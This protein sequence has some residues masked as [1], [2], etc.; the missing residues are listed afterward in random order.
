MR[1]L[2]IFRFEISHWSRRFSTWIY[3]GLLVVF[4]LYWT[5]ILSDPAGSTDVN[6]PVQI[7]LVLLIIGFVGVAITA[8]LFTDAAIR[9]HRLKIQPLLLTTPLR[10]WEYLGGR[11]L[12][13]LTINAL[14]LA[15]VPV[16][17]AVGT[18]MPFVDP[19]T[20][21]PFRPRAYIDPYLFLLL[22]GLVF[23]AAVLFGTSLL[24]RRAIS[25]YLTG[26][27]LFVGYVL[28]VAWTSTLQHPQLGTLLDPS[29]LLAVSETAEAWTF[30]ERNA[31]LVDASGLLLWNR[32][33]WMAIGLAVLGVT[34]SRYRRTHVERGGTS[35]SESGTGIAEDRPTSPL[36][37]SFTSLGVPVTAGSFG[38]QARLAQVLAITRWATRRILASREFIAVAV[39]MVVF[40]LLFGGERLEDPRYGV[41]LWPFTSEVIGLLKSFFI[42]TIVT[43]LIA[44]Y[45]GELVWEERDEGVDELTDVA[46]VPVWVSLVGRFVALGG[47]LIALHAVLLLAGILFQ[48]LS[49]YHDF[50]LGFFMKA[51][52]GFQLVD[53]LLIAAVAFFV[54]V[55][56]NQKYAGHGLVL[57]FYLCTVF[58]GRFGIE[59]GLLV[60]GSDPGWIASDFNGF[61]PFI[62]G[63]VWFKAYWAAWAL[64]LVL[65]AHLFWIRG[66]EQSLKQRLRRARGRITRPVAAGITG[67]GLLTLTLGGFVFYNTNVLN[68]YQSSFEAAQAR[69]EYERRYK[70][71]EN[72]AQPWVTNTRLRIEIYPDRGKA[73]AEGS[74][75]LV[76]ETADSIDAVHLS[77]VSGDV[78]SRRISFS[79]AAQQVI[80]D[81]ERGYR[82]YRLEQA[83]QPGDSLR[84]DFRIG[85]EPDGF[86]ENGITT[87]NSSVVSNG[88]F[89]HSRWLLPSVGYQRDLELASSRQR[90]EHGLGPREERPSIHDLSARR[91]PRNSS[92]G[93]WIDVETI[94]GTDED[95]V[96]VAPGSLIRTWTENGRR[97]SLFRTE[98][99]VLDFYAVLSADYAVHDV[100]WDDLT[101]QILHHP[102]HGVNVERM[103]ES[104]R[105]SLDY[106]TR[107]FGP[108]PYDQLR[109]VE[110]PGYRTFAR[111]YPGQM[112]YAEG[113][114]LH[115]RM[116]NGDSYIDSPLLVTAHEI[117]HQ[118][119]GHQVMGADVQGSP[120]L[121]ETLAQ[122]GALMVLEQQYGIESVHRFLR[123]MQIE[124]LNSRAGHSN[125]EVP[126][127]LS[128]DHGYIHSR[129][130]P[131]VM[132]ALK[133]YVGERQINSA[134]AR[135]VEAN[136]F[137]GPPFP[138]T[139]DLYA[140]LQNVTP[141]SLQYILE[142]LLTKITLWDLRTSEAR[143]VPAENDTYRVTL[144]IEARKLRADSVGND[145]E[146]SMNDM[147][148]IGVFAPAAEGADL[149]KALYLKKH[150]IE[151]GTQTITV[152]VPGK[153]ALAGI[154]PYHKL[155]SRQKDALVGGKIVEVVDG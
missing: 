59:H 62:A 91:V 96:A 5:V 89:L 109:L 24:T 150:R 68:D 120:V 149:G 64:L 50:R 20:L 147:I 67:A 49:G 11:F 18:Q 137:A 26:L 129:K 21:G 143:A 117:A 115:A 32:L 66:K 125:P 93:G 104:V 57:L 145:T 154:D 56:V 116:E 126:L 77:M 2:E 58:A 10:R 85:L 124:Y 127:L 100:R 27:V 98:A 22:P 133:D 19:E 99:P 43:L 138:T 1:L 74:Y 23:N 41:S 72:L 87:S 108:Y 71:Y 52:Y 135:L 48:V 8:A 113:S 101:V 75:S 34:F 44:F 112:V 142:D 9:D 7:A 114:S 4:G 55:A 146:V 70:Q 139:L 106:F 14:L 141:D 33:L 29:G 121:S 3:L 153:P 69:A 31:R 42:G 132:Y 28:A 36:S 79:R 12:G 92:R 94:V 63:F 103:V 122:Y 83:L 130:G 90:R 54:H 134:L 35:H 148:D 30:V 46:P 38:F 107:N 119:W 13:A 61:D 84:M 140:E 81:R 128:E 60:Y 40:I 88:S 78:L 155:I 80:D 95:Q 97:Y 17:M 6:A 123:T 51:L 111:A 53:H 47:M 16:S 65:G 39:G 73:E 144:Q 82:I 152:T 25:G 131:V 102:D 37:N 105:S 76:N 151:S 136:R 15:V 86:P 45:A 110:F 118:W